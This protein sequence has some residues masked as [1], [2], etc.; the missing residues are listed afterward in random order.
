MRRTQGQQSVHQ[1]NAS[2]AR[3][4]EHCA[5]FIPP[6]FYWTYS[7][8]RSFPP[9]GIGL[10]LWAVRGCSSRQLMLLKI[11]V[12]TDSKTVGIEA[13]CVNLPHISLYRLGH[14]GYIS[15]LR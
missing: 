4:P 15:P 5:H 10:C 13:V 6:F 12:D 2:V 1:R 14:I 11:V 8:Q 9:P 7:T 3:Y